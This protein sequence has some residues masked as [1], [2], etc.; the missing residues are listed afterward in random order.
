MIR[1]PRA[2]RRR[3]GLVLLQREVRETHPRDDSRLR[4]LGA[5]LAGDV[6]GDEGGHEEFGFDARGCLEWL[7][8]ALAGTCQEAGNRLAL[9]VG[10]AGDGGDAVLV[11]VEVHGYVFEMDPSEQWRTGFLS[12]LSLGWREEDGEL[13]CLDTAD[14]A[15]TGVSAPEDIMDLRRQ[16]RGHR[17]LLKIQLRRISF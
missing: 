7:V 3:T 5:R 1:R 4:G 17:W 2:R 15:F 9:E 11:V 16:E 6:L 8:E 13:G 14:G 10:E 12:A